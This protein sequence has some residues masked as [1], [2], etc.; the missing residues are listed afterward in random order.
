MYFSKVHIK[1]FRSIVDMELCF[2]PGINLLIGDNGVGKTAILEAIAV[3]IGGFFSGVA[4][5][6]AKNVLQSD[7]RITSKSVTK[8]S[9]VV[10]YMTPVEIACS[11]STSDG[12]FEWRRIRKDEN[13]RQ[14]T[15]VV[16]NGIAHYAREITNDFTKTLPVFSY[17][18]TYRIA[19]PK[20]GDSGR[21][22]KT[23][24]NDR[25]CGYIDCLEQALASKSIKEWCYDMESEA[26]HRQTN[27]PEYERFKELVATIMQE[28]ND[29]KQKPDIRYA[30]HYGDIVYTEGENILP[31]SYLS[32]GYQSVLWIAM[33]IAY[34]MTTLNPEVEDL[35]T[36]G[37]VVL[38]DELDMHLHP[39][40]QWKVLNAL[41]KA[42]PKVQFIVATHSAILIASCKNG[43]LISIDDDQCVTYQDDAYAYSLGDVVE[44]VQGST[45]LPASLRKLIKAFDRALNSENYED[46]EKIVKLMAE[47]YGQDNTEVKRAKA[48]LG[49]YSDFIGG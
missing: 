28:M 20:R 48:E 19:Q 6:S 21:K 29:L 39:K 25:R 42:F 35:S 44:F 24:L 32:A 40:W 3:G 41:N 34:R 37:G 18:S 46:A 31:I 17:L 23:K 9:S 7:I 33:D 22:L 26:F 14:K 43:H 47:E 30:S 16:G 36:V 45:R 12:Q 27:I 4:G 49:V 5:I 8:T 15:I 38:I 10:K 13:G 1:N 11:A 2:R